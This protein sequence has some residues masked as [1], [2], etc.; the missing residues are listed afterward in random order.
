[1]PT[2][3]EI[4]TLNTEPTIN[5]PILETVPTTIPTIEETEPIPEPTEEIV[6]PNEIIVR[7]I[8]NVNIRSCNSADALKIGLLNENDCAYKILS[9]DNNWDLVKV[10]DQFGYVCREYLE[11]TNETYESDYK[12]TP[13]TDIVIN[14]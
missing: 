1:M 2:E 10:G 3:I 5:Q 7:A 9:C 11:Y 12:Y 13:K 8:T 6:L 14:C 4:E